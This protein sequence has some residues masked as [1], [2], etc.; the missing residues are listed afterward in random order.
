MDIKRGDI[1]QDLGNRLVRAEIH[2]EQALEPNL[3]D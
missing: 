1:S 3:E 2:F